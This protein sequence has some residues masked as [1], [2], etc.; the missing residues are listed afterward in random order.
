MD[1]RA[2]RQLTDDGHGRIVQQEIWRAATT[3]SAAHLWKSAGMLHLSAEG[4]RALAKEL[5]QGASA[6]QRGL[7]YDDLIGQMLRRQR[8]AGRAATD[9]FDLHT[10]DLAGAPWMEID[11]ASDLAKAR[12]M[13]ESPGR[14]VS[15]VREVREMRE[16]RE[17]R[18]VADA[19]AAREAADA[20]AAR[21]AV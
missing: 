20:R 14:E 11:D 3:G 12:A 4:A 6:G 5:A 16:M 13:F 21:E 8:D 1:G 15:E 18:E 2:Q 10:L 19:R 9:G 17:A 7:Y